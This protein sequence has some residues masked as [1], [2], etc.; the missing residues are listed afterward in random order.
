MVYLAERTEQGIRQHDAITTAA[1]A[2]RDYPGDLGMGAGRI[3]DHAQRRC[4][5]V[6][7][8]GFA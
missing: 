1:L 2:V 5:L 7:Q 6:L 8:P 4:P 3:A